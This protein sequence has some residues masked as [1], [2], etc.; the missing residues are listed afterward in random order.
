MRGRETGAHG[1]RDGDEP[2]WHVDR[3]HLH[4]VLR[5]RAGLVG[6]DHRRR[7]E[8]LDARQMAHERVPPRHSPRGHRHR[9]RH[10][11]EQSLRHVRDD[12]ANRKDETDARRQADECADDE[13]ETADGDRQDGDDPA[14]SGDFLLK[15]RRHVGRGSA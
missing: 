7:P 3:S 1:I 11:R 8:C 5:Q 14:Q 6:A 12:D 15:W 2:V 9:Q 4:P 10:G 13:H